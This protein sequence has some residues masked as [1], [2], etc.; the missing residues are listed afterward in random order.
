MLST[1]QRPYCLC[2]CQP[3]A[4]WIASGRKTIEVRSRR[5]NYRGP[6]LI[7][8]TKRPKFGSL[9]AG[10]IVCQVDVVDCRPW[11]DDD[12]AA[13]LCGPGHGDWSWIL[14]NVRRLDDPIPIRGQQGMFRVGLTLGEDA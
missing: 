13:A 7:A 9:P 4:E 10:A 3:W 2:V 5:T 8:A 14:A 12:V 6:L 11:S 1:V